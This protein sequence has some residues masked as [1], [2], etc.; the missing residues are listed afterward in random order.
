MYKIYHNNML[1]CVAPFRDCA[2]AFI[3]GFTGRLIWI[4]D[5]D[6]LARY[7]LHVEVC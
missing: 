3:E 7:G 5:R 1:V 4:L 2:T 6:F